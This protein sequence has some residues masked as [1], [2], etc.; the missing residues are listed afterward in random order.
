ME[1]CISFRGSQGESLSLL[2]IQV[3]GRIWFLVVVIFVLV[4]SWGAV[5]SFLRSPTFFDW[6]E[7][8]TV[9]FT[10]SLRVLSGLRMKSTSDRPTGERH[11]NLLERRFSWPGSLYKGWGPKQ[12]VKPTC[13]YSRLNRERQLWRSDSTMWAGWSKIRVILTRM[14]CIDFSWSKL[15]VLDD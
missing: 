4:F 9:T 1:G 10:E 12:V 2:I 5:H 13:S 6:Q 3:I 7:K 11:T 15:P 8:Q 14:V